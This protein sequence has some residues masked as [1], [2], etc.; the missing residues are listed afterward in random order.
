MERLLREDIPQ[1]GQDALDVL[2]R[3]ERDVLSNMMHT[4][5]P[6]FFAFIPGPGN[7]IGAMADALA[8][9][10]NVFAGTW[11]EGAGPAQ[12]ELVTLDWLRSACGLPARAGGLFTSGGSA[13]NLAALAAARHV[14]LEGEM[15][16]AVAYVSDQTHSSMERAFR[17]LGFGPEQVR[18]LPSDGQYRLS[19]AALRAAVQH[20]RSAGLRPFCV[21][22][23]PGTTNTGAIDPLP[24]LAAFC[25][26]EN[27]WLHA[28]GAYGAAAVFCERGRRLLEGLG[29]VDSLS[30]DPHKWLFQPY[31]MG[32]VLVRERRWLRD[33]FHV[34]PEYMEDTAGPEGEVNFCDYG[35]QLSRRFRALK[36]WMSLQ[37][38]GADAFSAAVERGF[39]L[40]EL[41]EMTLE[42][43]DRLRV[44][45]P[46]QMGV[47]TFQAQPQDDCLAAVNS[48]NRALV[49]AIL[50]D[51]Y[52]M[53]VSTTLR[54]QTVLRMCTINPRT[55]DEDIRQT[56]R[57]VDLLSR[58]IEEGVVVRSE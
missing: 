56:I 39:E 48:H 49:D 24:Q 52:A 37:V 27:L 43:S 30:I 45:T 6:R 42:G 50:D 36:L 3:T 16:G 1:K 29:E 15:Q 26:R 18:K 8:S 17:I 34:L 5:H 12:V 28:D 53:I 40:A 55:T 31:E 57:R 21:I 44:V 51:G 13:A 11:L 41:A 32:C 33:C 22:A 38:F 4:S 23:T 20:D 25:R 54:G 2:Q 58:A 9:G 35:P 19:L 14:A 10:Y 47:V 7:F 46:A